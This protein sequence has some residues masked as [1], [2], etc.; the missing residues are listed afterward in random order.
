M[1]SQVINVPPQPA[2]KAEGGPRKLKEEAQSLSERGPLAPCNGGAPWKS[3]EPLG[4]GPPKP[5][6]PVTEASSA[7]EVEWVGSGRPAGEEVRGGVWV[8]VHTGGSGFQKA[9]P[10][11]MT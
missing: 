11:V 4:R 9:P 5:E 8:K 10:G 3:G 6:C 7:F 1:R 2:D